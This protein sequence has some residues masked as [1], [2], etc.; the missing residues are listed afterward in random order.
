LY[1]IE[2]VE[3]AFMGWYGIMKSIAAVKI[4]I[5]PHPYK[6]LPTFLPTLNFFHGRFSPEGFYFSGIAVAKACPYLYFA[7]FLVYPQAGRSKGYPF[8]GGGWGETWAHSGG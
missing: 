3:N 2:V 7:C 4:A 1:T 6:L 8:V 5:I